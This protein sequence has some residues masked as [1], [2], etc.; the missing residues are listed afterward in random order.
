MVIVFL[1][2]ICAAIALLEA[3]LVRLVSRL[4]KGPAVPWRTAVYWGGVVVIVT[5]FFSGFS[6][7]LP[8]AAALLSSIVGWGGLH[9]GL[10]GLFMTTEVRG[11]D[12]LRQPWRWGAKVTGIAGALLVIGAAVIACVVWFVEGLVEG[13]IS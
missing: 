4:V 7:R 12:G 11:T 5:G 6:R 9:V 8:D 13:A 3:L 10:G 1:L 2:V